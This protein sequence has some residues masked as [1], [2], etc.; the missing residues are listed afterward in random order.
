[1]PLRKLEKSVVGGEVAPALKYADR[2]HR[3]VVFGRRETVR[4]ETLVEIVEQ[5]L[6]G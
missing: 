4:G 5:L 2:H 1:M 3:L 6:A